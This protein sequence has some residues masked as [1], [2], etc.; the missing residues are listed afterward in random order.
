MGFLGILGL[1]G[2]AFFVILVYF[3]FTGIKQKR[4]KRVVF[5]IIGFAALIILMYLGLSFLITSM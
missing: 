2:L 4:W 3:V 1:I 5:P